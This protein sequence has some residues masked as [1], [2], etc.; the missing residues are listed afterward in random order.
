MLIYL[1]FGNLNGE[2]SFSVE[3]SIITLIVHLFS[4]SDDSCTNVFNVAIVGNEAINVSNARNIDNL[5]N[6]N[7]FTCFTPNKD[8]DFALVN[9]CHILVTLVSSV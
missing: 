3:D 8:I 9:R 6:T 4:C 2:N 7:L 1:A 5:L